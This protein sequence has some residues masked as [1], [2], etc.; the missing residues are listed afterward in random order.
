MNIIILPHQGL[1][2]QIIMNGYVNYLLL[3][4][5][6]KNII[7]I[8]K[9]YQKNTLEHLYKDSPQVLFFFT[10]IENESSSYNVFKGIPFLELIN[11]KP[12]NTRVIINNEIFFIHN[13]GVHSDV[14]RLVVAGKNWADSFYLNANVDPSLRYTMFKVPSDMK[15]SKELYELLKRYIET[16]QYILIH[17]DPSRA[18][19]IKGDLVKSVLETNDHSLLPIIYLGKNRNQYPFI[20]GLN[21]KELPESF[22]TPSLLNMY[23]IIYN[24]TECHFMDSSIACLTDTMKG[25]SSKLYL[26]YY[27]TENGEQVDSTEKVHSNRKWVPFHI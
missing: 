24:A 13:F 18:R 19:Y 23:D 7:I 10:P 16:S 9:Q 2:D 17:D 27:M 11:E 1:G 20:Q 22:N 25:S 14:K 3:N 5:Q 4:N 8:A 15:V 12:F 6:V 21:N 26:H